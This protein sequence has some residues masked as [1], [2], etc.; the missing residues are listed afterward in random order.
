MN[1]ILKQLYFSTW[2]II[3]AT[4]KLMK[5][6]DTIEFSKM[7]EQTDKRTVKMSDF[8]TRG[9]CEE[10]IS[11]ALIAFTEIAEKNLKKGHWNYI[12][13]ADAHIAFL[14]DATIRHFNNTIDKFIKTR[15]PFPFPVSDLRKKF[16]ET[17]C[18]IVTANE[19]IKMGVIK[20][21]EM[22]FDDPFE[23]YQHRI[24]S[25]G[26]AKKEKKVTLKQ[27][28]NSHD[29]KIRERGAYFTELVDSTLMNL[30]FDKMTEGN[31]I[32]LEAKRNKNGSVFTVTIDVDKE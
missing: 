32:Q 18:F 29:E 26:I 11:T 8:I 27:G 12:F 13:H 15:L 21:G 2:K 7:K 4:E 6:T 31:S 14:T 28:K 23:K 16:E 17:D 5:L 22:C 25:K 30:L 1:M 9:N 24:L 20:T 3:N 10:S 19:L